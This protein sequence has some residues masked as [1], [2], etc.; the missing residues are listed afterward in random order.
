MGNGGLTPAMERSHFALW[1]LVKA[2]LLIGADLRN[3]SATSLAVL[4]SP[5]VIAINQVG[6]GGGGGQLLEL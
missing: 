5:E 1:A 6:R 3:I 2:P 4:K